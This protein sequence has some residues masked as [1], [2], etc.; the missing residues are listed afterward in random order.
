MVL[1]QHTRQTILQPPLS[2][3]TRGFAEGK[4]GVISDS[5]SFHGPVQFYVLRGRTRRILGEG[6]LRTRKS[7][8]PC[9]FWEHVH[10]MEVQGGGLHKGHIS[11]TCF[12]QHCSF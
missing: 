1:P 4:E 12:E 10:R 5:V 3:G 8:A 7:W 11:A 9:E 6:G 2:L